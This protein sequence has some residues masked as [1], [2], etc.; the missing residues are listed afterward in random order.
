[1]ISELIIL[2]GVAVFMGW[3]IDL[4]AI[5]GIIVAIGT[6]VDDQ[7]V[8]TDESFNKGKEIGQS[9]WKSRLKRAFFVIIGSY[10]TTVVAML[11][12]WWAGAGLLKGFSLTTIAGVTIGVFITRRAYA[13]TIEIIFK[14]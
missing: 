12:L 11:P 2:L 7:I 13:K 1:M 8:I 10:L 4:V 9:G 5:G 6:G 14:D 3:Q